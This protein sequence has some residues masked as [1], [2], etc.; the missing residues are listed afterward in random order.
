MAS[1]PTVV[2]GTDQI[3]I[4]PEIDGDDGPFVLVE[5]PLSFSPAMLSVPE[6]IALMRA[7]RAAIITVDN[8]RA[9]MGYP[10]PD[11]SDDAVLALMAVV[12]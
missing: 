3:S 11:L 4:R 5:T 12:E 8:V 1:I 9:V 7:L 10:A 6:C 2:I